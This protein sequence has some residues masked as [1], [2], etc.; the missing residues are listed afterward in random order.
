MSRVDSGTGRKSTVRSLHPAR[1]RS[2]PV[3]RPDLRANA[4]VAR[5]CRVEFSAHDICISAQA[6]KTYIM[7]ETINTVTTVDT[8]T[9]ATEA[10]GG[11]PA[12]APLRAESRRAHFVRHPGV[13]H[14]RGGIASIC[15]HRH[16]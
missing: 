1:F 6:R 12:A 16:R 2:A 10:I 5:H 4:R 13:A 9:L 15:G 11:R 8:R 7:A 3:T 14:S